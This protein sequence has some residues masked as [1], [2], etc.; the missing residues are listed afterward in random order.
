MREFRH[1]TVAFFRDGFPLGGKGF[2]LPIEIRFGFREF[3]R[4]GIARADEV[5]SIEVRGAF[6]GR[7]LRVGDRSDGRCRHDR[8]LLQFFRA[9]FAEPT[10]LLRIWRA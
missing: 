10:Q 6:R 9:G 7:G 5:V 8:D 4:R 3:Q 1:G 2:G